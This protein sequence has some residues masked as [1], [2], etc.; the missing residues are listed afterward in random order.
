M[1]IT[2]TSS[3][4]QPSAPPFEALQQLLPEPSAPSLENLLPPPYGAPSFS[5]RRPG[6][7]RIIQTG[8]PSQALAT[9]VKTKRTMKS[10]GNGLLITSG[11]FA[12]AAVSTIPFLPASIVLGGIAALLLIAGLIAKYVSSSKTPQEQCYIDFGLSFGCSIWNYIDWSSSTP[13]IK[14][15]QLDQ[16]LASLFAQM[17]AAGQTTIDLGFSQLENIDMFLSGDFSGPVDSSDVVKALMQQ[18]QASNVQ[19]PGY[20]NFLQYLCARAKSHGMKVS[21]SL[22]GAVA[23][24]KNMH[25]LQNNTETFN[26]QAQKLAALMKTYGIDAVDFD[27]EDPTALTSQGTDNLGQGVMEFF[28]SL[29]HELDQGGRTMTLTSCLDVGWPKNTFREFFFDDQGKPIFSTLFHGL[30][31]MAY[32][33]SQ[34]YLD[35]DNLSWGMTQWLDIVGPENAGLVNVGFD[36]GVPYNQAGAS[37]SGQVYPFT[38]GSSAGSAAAQIYLALQADLNSRGYTTPLGNPFFWPAVNVQ[39]HGQNRYAVTGNQSNFVSSDM[40]DFYNYLS[41][42]G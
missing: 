16:Y 17:Q 30:N 12:I 13:K 42:H 8:M 20:N 5:P 32:S 1:S 34:Y 39:P 10:V 31:L 21:L 22:G 41:V 25:I 38:P 4:P 35:A 9:A 29:R 36:D 40:Q 2:T 27:I 18:L 24:D 28:R 19:T 23:T 26:G 33:D 6:N 7:G 15:D 37:G 11:A 14:T 3:L